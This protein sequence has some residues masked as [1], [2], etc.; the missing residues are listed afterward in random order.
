MLA[1]S[2]HLMQGTPYIYQGEEIG[3]TNPGFTDMSQY[4]D[5]E[6]LNM[7]QLMVEQGDTSHDDMMAILRQKSRDN[8]RTPM[9]WNGSDHAG[10]T[11]GTPWI[12]VADNYPEINAEAAV[13]DEQSVFYFYKELIELRKQLPVIRE[14]SYVD[15]FPEHPQV[16][17]YLRETEDA[18]LLCLNNYYGEETSIEV[19]QQLNGFGGS[20][21]LSNLNREEEVTLNGSMTLMSYETLAVLIKK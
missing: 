4:R 7:Y 8:S 18:M 12:G 6:S 1:A 21:V 16:H 11:Q 9:Q 2:V 20:V 19:P 17:G 3:M 13:K 10:F 5:V 15:L 14:G